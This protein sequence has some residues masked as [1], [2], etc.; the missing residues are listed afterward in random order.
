MVKNALQKCVY[1]FGEYFVFLCCYNK[2]MS[3]KIMFLLYISKRGNL[4]GHNMLLE[5][6]PVKGVLHGNYRLGGRLG[7]DLLG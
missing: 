3:T 2:L 5:N 4:I 6:S 1:V 7:E